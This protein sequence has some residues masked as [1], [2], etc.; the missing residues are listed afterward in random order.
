MIPQCSVQ[1]ISIP[2]AYCYCLLGSY[3]IEL[4]DWIRLKL[5]TKIEYRS[6]CD[7]SCYHVARVWRA[8]VAGTRDKWP[9]LPCPGMRLPA[10]QQFAYPTLVVR[11]VSDV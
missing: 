2:C 9:V 1:F 8:G 7:C 6:L 5:T 4:K 10:D 11:H 3:I